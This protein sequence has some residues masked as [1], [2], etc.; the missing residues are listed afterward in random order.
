MPQVDRVKQ[1]QDAHAG[2]TLFVTGISPRASEAHL[3]AAFAS[4]GSVKK[5]SISQRQSHHPF[6]VGHV[7]YYDASNAAR[8]VECKHVSVCGKQVVA[9]LHKT[10]RKVLSPAKASPLRTPDSPPRR[11]KH[12]MQA[13]ARDRGRDKVPPTA[14]KEAHARRQDAQSPP[15]HPK[16]ASPP[17]HPRK[18]R[19]GGAGA[20]S[21]MGA[22]LSTPIIAND[23]DASVDPYCSQALPEARKYGDHEFARSPH[24]RPPK[25]EEPMD[26]VIVIGNRYDSVSYRV[27]K[28]PRMLARA[29]DTHDCLRGPP[30]EDILWEHSQNSCGG[31]RGEEPLGTQARIPAER[32]ERR[33]G[34]K[35]YTAKQ[36]AQPG[37]LIYG[38]NGDLHLQLDESTRYATYQ[39]LP[40]ATSSLRGPVYDVPV[41]RLDG[42][43]YGWD[44]ASLFINLA[45][46]GMPVQA[47]LIY[48]D[49]DDRHLRQGLLEVESPECAQSLLACGWLVVQCINLQVFPSVVRSIATVC[50]SYHN[51]SAYSRCDD[52]FNRPERYGY[53]YS[54][55]SPAFEGAAM[56]VAASALGP[57]MPV[58]MQTGAWNMMSPFQE[59]HAAPVYAAEPVGFFRSAESY[60]ALMPSSL[61]CSPAEESLATP[62]DEYLPDAMR[63]EIFDPSH[64][65][66]YAPS[67]GDWGNR[68]YVN[69]RMPPA[70]D[71]RALQPKASQTVVVENFDKEIVK[72]A[73][74]LAELMSQYGPVVAAD[75]IPVSDRC[76]RAYITFEETGAANTALKQLNGCVSGSSSLQA[77]LA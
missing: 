56:P 14:S 36:E 22:S 49:V 15:C 28:P 45:D 7:T 65:Y 6:R 17:V 64:F 32:Q 24:L 11:G 31:A 54:N 66:P 30:R 55:D 74:A 2:R 1:D 71:V 77:R 8:A 44:A 59:G 75:I 18:R 63:P 37:P 67:E 16:C 42:I 3:A 58:T 27:G 47:T 50:A 40:Q 12:G 68:N 23:A 25:Q 73:S 38:D 19:K 61:P 72:D 60:P 5:A 76:V 34:K 62:K 51:L 20:K 35:K 57:A 46:A 4:F 9:K 69:M 33:H 41:V 13:G 26:N 52:M 43:P 29:I 21:P 10:D 53:G 39:T 48:N 70:Y